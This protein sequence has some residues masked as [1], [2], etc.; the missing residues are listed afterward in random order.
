MC[1]Y[2]E[3]QHFMELRKIE[4]FQDTTIKLKGVIWGGISI[5]FGKLPLYIKLKNMQYLYIERILNDIFLPL[6]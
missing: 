4:E 3:I 5:K 6:L 1:I 2:F